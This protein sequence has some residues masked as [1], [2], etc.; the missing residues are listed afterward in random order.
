MSSAQLKAAAPVVVVREP[1]PLPPTLSSV[2]T[3]QLQQ[4]L[5]EE[6]KRGYEAGMT[7]AKEGAPAPEKEL[8]H[9]SVTRT[10]V[11][12]FTWRVLSTATTVTLAL[13]LFNDSIAADAAVELGAVEFLS[14]YGLYFIHERAW[15][16]ITF[17]L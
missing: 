3:E 13:W 16:A 6:Y 4:L 1:S 7:A 2:D 11:K 15:A 5:L 10:A 8:V 17:L 14:K 12:S 9:D